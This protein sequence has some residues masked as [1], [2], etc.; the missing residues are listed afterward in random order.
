MAN[1]LLLE[2]YP[3]L[4]RI[5]STILK[6]D[7]HKV[8]AASNGRE[9]LGLADQHDIDLVLVDILMPIMGG[10]DFLKEY[11][12]KNNHPDVKAIVLTNIFDKDIVEQAK[13]LGASDY[14]IKSDIKPSDIIR[15][16]N[17]TLG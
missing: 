17:D 3:S 12:I 13:K 14:I 9:G 11:D 16:V 4:Q 2:D 10:I 15:I 8:Y 7:N 6:S 1:I 5:F